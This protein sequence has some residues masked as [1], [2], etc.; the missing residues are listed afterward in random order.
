MNSLH[1]STK[2]RAANAG[3]S[4]LTAGSDGNFYGTLA[5]AAGFGNQGGVFKI[6]PGGKFTLIDGFVSTSAV[7]DG[8]SIGV[9]MGSDGRLYGTTGAGGT[10]SNGTIYRMTTA[11]TNVTALHNINNNTE[12]ANGTGGN[13]VDS[14]NLL[15]P[16]TDGKFY[17]A[18]FGGG[19]GNQG[20][21]YQLTSAGVFSSFLFDG[22]TKPNFG[23]NPSAPL[24]QHTNGT[25]FG[26]NTG[27]GP[28][29][30]AGTFFSLNIGASPFIR[31]VSPVPGGNEGSQ[32]GILG[33]GFS[34]SSVV[35]FGGVTATGACRIH[36]GQNPSGH[37]GWR[38]FD[39]HHFH[40]QL[41]TRLYVREDTG[42]RT[43]GRTPGILEVLA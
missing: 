13:G 5:D 17:G 3:P 7:G 16:A 8:P 1:C 11:G 37:Q 28:S 31:L 38:H 21:I 43:R 6:T 19:I 39:R 4:V 42:V 29:G 23:T 27:W 40:G 36:H 32:I 24:M 14:E 34:A 18:N 10:D 22:T 2:P 9:T 12:G 15:L 20:A 30:T 35:K 41:N 25:I 26:N 33:Q